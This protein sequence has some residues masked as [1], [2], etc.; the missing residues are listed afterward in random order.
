MTSVINRLRAWAPAASFT[1]AVKQVR[2]QSHLAGGES[3]QNCLAR[4]TFKT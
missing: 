3:L 2:G 1:S 4:G